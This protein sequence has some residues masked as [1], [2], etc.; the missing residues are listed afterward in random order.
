[1][2]GDRVQGR[3]WVWFGGRPAIDFA[4][5]VRERAT[6]WRDLLE[7][8]A[9]LAGWFVAAGIGDRPLTVDDELLTRARELREAIDQ[10]IR[11]ILLE[12]D[13]P[14]AS[15]Q[16]INAW[17]V[18]A[19]GNPPHLDTSQRVPVLR[20][21]TTTPSDAHGALCRIALDAAELIGTDARAT[22]RVCASAPCNAL[23]VDKSAGRRRR[24]CSMATCG[25]RA[26]A[27]QFRRS[28]TNR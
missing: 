18:R 5:T 27:A 8:P 6:A 17:L 10:G 11:A 26:K 24:W 12:E 1:M 4:N 20:T 15:E 21:L 9:D 25:N 7:T 28:A 19:V 16:I 14:P 3:P 23:F 2:D 13:F 22:I